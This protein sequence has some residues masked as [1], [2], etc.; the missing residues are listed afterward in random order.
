LKAADI[1]RARSLAEAYI[2]K[3]GGGSITTQLGDGGSA[4][5]FKWD[6][7]HGEHALKV[8]DPTFLASENAPAERHRLALQRR[9]IGHHC[10]SLIDTL[11]IEEDAGTCFVK[12]EYFSGSE[13][14]KVL[15]RVPDAMV[16]GL[17]GQLVAAVRFLEGYGLVHRDIKPENMLVSQDFRILKLLDLGVVREISAE[18]DRSDRTDHGDKRP[19]I[20]TAQYS[21]PEYLFR[22]EP[23]SSQLW[24]ALTIYQVGG[25]LHD[26]VC[27][28]A[29]FERA[30]A[31]ENKYALAMS[32]MRDAP[33][34]DGASTDMAAWTALAARCLT[35]DSTL[36][37]QLVD[38]PDFDATAESPRDRLRRALSARAATVDRAIASQTRAQALRQQ[39]NARVLSVMQSLRARVVAEYSPQIRVANLFQDEGRT[40]SVLGL[41][42]SELGVQLSVEFAWQ[43]GV[44][45]GMSSVRLSAKVSPGKEMVESSGERLPIGE[46][47]SDG[48]AEAQLVDSIVEAV[49]EILVRY[50]LLAETGSLVDGAD[51]VALIWKS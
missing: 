43:I 50:A 42:D 46:V 13:L 10:D 31:A 41:A 7:P 4:A 9:L 26:L 51:M 48:T 32:V 6:G 21:S 17:I 33:S 25:V 22:L 39:R 40:I 20:A 35:K 14:K 28:R 11:S 34:F 8:Y 30:V 1:A 23:P 44:R 24:K 38:W 18:E 19:F 49:S 12:M 15:G 36:R 47:D 29:L 16:P 37:L 45:E 3:Q 27:K 2:A 5:V